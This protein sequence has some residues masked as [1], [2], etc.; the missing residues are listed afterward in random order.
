MIFPSGGARKSLNK[1]KQ[2]R[3]NHECNAMFVGRCPLNARLPSPLY[4]TRGMSLRVG[5]HERNL[6]PASYLSPRLFLA[7]HI[8]LVYTIAVVA[9]LMIS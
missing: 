3:I 8:L 1:L 6:V 9:V 5:N 7:D 2:S 4:G